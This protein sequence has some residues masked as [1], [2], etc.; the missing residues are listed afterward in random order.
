[1]PRHFVTGEELDRDELRVI[2][3]RA[4]ELKA[5]RLASRVLEGRSVAL[6][7][8]K[9]STRTRLSMEAGVFELGGHPLVL[10]SGELQ[11]SR[12]ESIR[13]T[14]MV[15]SRHVAA[16]G[17]RT[18]PDED[19]LELARHSTV[20]VINLLTAGHHPIQVLADLVTG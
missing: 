15:F 9:P 16:I 17:I 18:G 3:E 1:L 14:A 8:E 7:F 10:R 4:L 13:D 11:V 20:P 5:D 6:V 2:V 12:G 19:V